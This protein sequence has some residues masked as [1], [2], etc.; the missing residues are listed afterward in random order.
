MLFVRCSPLVPLPEIYLS[1][2]PPPLLPPLEWMSLKAGQEWLDL[3]RGDANSIAERKIVHDAVN[4]SNLLYI[5][6]AAPRP[7][8]FVCLIGDM[9]MLMCTANY[10]KCRKV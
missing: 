10:K 3:P 4:V 9:K 7:C 6:A 8:Q 1:L 5:A 2:S